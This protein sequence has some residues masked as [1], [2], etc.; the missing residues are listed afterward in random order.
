MTKGMLLLVCGGV[1]IFEEYG[2]RDDYRACV[3]CD[4]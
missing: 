4:E 2:I 1:I 3:F